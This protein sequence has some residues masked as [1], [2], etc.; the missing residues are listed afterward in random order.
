MS[1]RLSAIL[2]R[3]GPATPEPTWS[4]ARSQMPL[5]ALSTENRQ[6]VQVVTKHGE[7]VACI[8]HAPSTRDGE[9]HQLAHVSAIRWHPQHTT[10]FVGWTSGR[11]SR[12]NHR[13]VTTNSS[14]DIA[15][16]GSVQFIDLP[17]SAAI[18]NIAISTKGQLC[19][20]TDS[21]GGAV[22]SSL[23][24]DNCAGKI[25]SPICEYHQHEGIRF[26]AF[27]CRKNGCT[28][29]QEQPTFFLTGNSAVVLEADHLGHCFRRYTSTVP[30]LL[31]DY[32]AASDRLVLL[33]AQGCRRRVY[34]QCRRRRTALSSELAWEDFELIHE[35][36]RDSCLSVAVFEGDDEAV[37]ISGKAALSLLSWIEPTFAADAGLIALQSGLTEI[38]LFM[39]KQR[40]EKS[41]D[42]AEPSPSGTDALRPASPF[43]FGDSLPSTASTRITT[44]QPFTG[45]TLNRSM[46]T[47]FNTQL[48]TVFKITE[49]HGSLLACAVSCIETTG[50]TGAAAYVAGSSTTLFLATPRGVQQMSLEGQDRGLLSE[51]ET[52]D[53]PMAAPQLL[54]LKGDTL[55]VLSEDTCLSVWRL[56]KGAPA[57]L[58][59][60]KV[61]A[62]FAEDEAILVKS[63][64][65]AKDGSRISFVLKRR[66][67][68]ICLPDGGDTSNPDGCCNR[69]VPV[70]ERSSAERM[71]EE[72]AEEE[73]GIFDVATSSLRIYG[74]E[75]L[76]STK[77]TF[78]GWDERDTRLLACCV[79]RPENPA[80]TG[81][82]NEEGGSPSSKQMD[83]SRPYLVTF[84]IDPDGRLAEQECMPSCV[85]LVEA[86]STLATPP[87]AV[88][89][90]LTAS[91]WP[92]SRLV[93]GASEYLPSKLVQ[94]TPVCLG[95]PFFSFVYFETF[96]GPNGLSNAVSDERA[97]AGGTHG[98]WAV[99]SWTQLPD[100]Q[101]QRRQTWR[102]DEKADLA[103]CTS[104]LNRTGQAA[105]PRLVK[106][107]MRD[108]RSLDLK[109]LT[110]EV[111]SSVT[112]VSYYLAFN[113]V[114]KAYQALSFTTSSKPLY[115]EMAKISIKTRRL[116]IA[117]KCIGKL[118][119]PKLHA[120]LR[121][122]EH[123][124]DEVKLALAAIH[125]GLDDEV[126]PLYRSCGRFDLLETWLQANA[127]WDDALQVASQAG[128]L[129]SLHTHYLYS[130]YLENAGDYSNALNHLQLSRA[131]PGSLSQ[132][133]SPSNCPSEP[134]V[135]CETKRP[136]HSAP[137]SRCFSSVSSKEL[138][139]TSSTKEPSLGQTTRVTGWR[140][141]SPR[142]LRLAE[143]TGDVEAFLHQ[144]TDPELYRWHGVRLEKHAWE[145]EPGV[146]VYPLETPQ[147]AKASNPREKLGAQAR[148]KEALLKQA[149]KWYSRGKL[150]SHQVRVLCSTDQIDEARKVCSETGDQDACLLLAHELEKRGQVQEAVRLYTKAGRLRKALSLG[151]Q[152]ELD[153]DLMAAALN[154]SHE[155]L[156][157]AAASFY[158]RREYEK[159]VALFRKAG[160]LDTALQVCLAANL[161]DSLRLLADEATPSNDPSV[162]EK[163]AAAFV[164]AG[165]IDRAIQLLAK[166]KRFD[167]A[168]QL[169]ENR[170][171]VLSDSLVKAL[172]PSKDDAIHCIP[173]TATDSRGDTTGAGGSDTDD[174]RDRETRTAFE[175][176]RGVLIR[177]GK[178]CLRQKLFHQACRSFTAAGEIVTAIDCLLKT[179]DTEKII[180]FAQTARHPE[181]YIA[182]ANYL[183]GLDHFSDAKLRTSIVSFY[184]KAKAF[185]K[186]AAFYINLAQMEIEEHSEYERALSSLQESRD[187]LIHCPDAA[188]KI[189]LLEARIDI[190]TRYI[191]ATRLRAED[192]DAMA[193]ELVLLLKTPAAEKVLKIGDVFSELGRYYNSIGNFAA[194][195]FLIKKMQERNL[196]VSLYL[197]QEIIGDVC[198][199]TGSV[200]D[201][202]EFHDHGT[203]PPR[204][205]DRT[206]Q[207]REGTRRGQDVSPESAEVSQGFDERSSAVALMSDFEEPGNTQDDGL[208]DDPVDS[209]WEDGRTVEAP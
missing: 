128:R 90:S 3:G 194:V 162:V 164:D 159:A 144:Q 204:Q 91:G 82:R 72:D 97:S 63:M 137:P 176:R 179:G 73:L 115:P 59:T 173:S 67:Q 192:P 51:R 5:L 95:T 193:R 33:T 62:S 45:L 139:S 141:E 124:E 9:A 24:E 160:Q 71:T 17:H 8:Q 199:A 65:G 178:L 69:P 79:W 166:T 19:V 53:P 177:L 2:A 161:R 122:A 188:K 114:E 184:Q 55:G 182:A 80:D 61:E 125:L 190:I 28:S 152:E 203:S 37:A 43:F 74:S 25:L 197:S 109:A 103:S 168:L 202:G 39:E 154:A 98:R 158:E 89:D 6:Q 150:R 35:A 172:T 46:L 106:R 57:L 86:K 29:N 85:P 126:E 169:C 171:L 18:T 54:W 165:M 104:S 209:D 23:E 99:R 116:E 52:L 30:L 10:L 167:A 135:A 131:S 107:L 12:W 105:S 146:N 117:L 186:L 136:L 148:S 118:K 50:V 196:P 127:K 88:I 96:S 200:I 134:A 77:I 41:G 147:D 47:V 15:E 151:Q 64:V 130:M 42:N 110:E 149:L 31:V 56:G 157:A 189:D 92:D 1:L 100:S 20:S 102:V 83:S 145:T 94:P 16:E 133:T 120:A 4:G 132:I 113:N 185:P 111:I 70:A 187:Y 119:M 58:S 21:S 108:F 11:I 60:G 87:R 181:V 13:S 121:K 155:D 36:D 49:D 112:D 68:R 153:S 191:D 78:H 180:Y 44:R 14:E 174:E 143:K 34:C 156:V 75:I 163:C 140:Y 201:E 27:R 38:S 101:E 66:K 183:Q 84:F 32:L 81:S 205:I 7:T 207:W 123:E 175:A 142:V 170:H 76:G 208:P 138:A 206:S 48:V 198:A 93:G 195:R 26:S 129:H 22:V 40:E